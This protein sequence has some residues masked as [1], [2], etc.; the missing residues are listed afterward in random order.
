MRTGSDGLDR[1]LHL[2]HLLRRHLELRVRR[3]RMH[4]EVLHEF[5]FRLDREAARAVH[6]HVGTRC[7][8]SHQH[9]PSSLSPRTGRASARNRDLSIR[10]CGVVAG[11][12]SRRSQPCRLRT[13]CPRLRGWTHRRHPLLRVR[14]GVGVGDLARGEALE[15]GACSR[16]SGRHPPRSLLRWLLLGVDARAGRGRSDKRRGDGRAGGDHLRREALAARRRVVEGRRCR[17]PNCSPCS[18]PSR[19]GCCPGY[20]RPCRAGCRW[21]PSSYPLGTSAD[22]PAQLPAAGAPT[23]ERTNSVVVRG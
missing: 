7:R 19:R 17:V 4:R 11:G 18:C 2:L 13:F 22:C 10:L 14:V 16:S 8:L 20:G 9:P 3:A 12:P 23:T 15:G 6:P 5:I 21:G 1:A